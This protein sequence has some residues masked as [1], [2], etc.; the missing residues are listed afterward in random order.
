M[1]VVRITQADIGAR[2][3]I[4]RRI[5]GPIPLSD[6]LG[7]L[8]SWSAHVL[9]VET[10]EGTRVQITEDDVV[11]ARAIPPRPPARRAR[12]GADAQVPT[13]PGR[14]EAAVDIPAPGTIVRTRP[15]RRAT[16]P[17]MTEQGTAPNPAP[18]TATEATGG[19]AAPPGDAGEAAPPGDAGETARG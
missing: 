17:D 14:L 4:R 15:V 12:A 8:R 5:P 7:T 2:V 6:V 16:I 1:Y 18:G 3:M 10:A 13:A 11:A 9:T 19:Q